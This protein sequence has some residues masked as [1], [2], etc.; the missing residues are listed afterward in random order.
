[1]GTLRDQLIYPHNRVQMEAYGVNDMELCR[2]LALVD[3]A[4]SILR[5]WNLDDVCYTSFIIC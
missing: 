5:Q 3:P 4:N 1:M 2:L